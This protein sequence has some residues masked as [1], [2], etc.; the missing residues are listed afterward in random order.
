MRSTHIHMK[1]LSMVHSLAATIS[2]H[3]TA[4]AMSA[5]SPAH[6][7]LFCIFPLPCTNSPV[8]S[9][10]AT[11]TWLLCSR[12]SP[13]PDLPRPPAQM[14]PLPHQPSSIHKG[15]HPFIPCQIVYFA[16]VLA[17]PAIFSACLN[18]AC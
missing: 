9:D 2:K 8:V 7:F 1:Q 10:P 14:F 3:F 15:P 18:S 16:S 6:F 12:H 5:N 13:S 17:G 4:V 11:L